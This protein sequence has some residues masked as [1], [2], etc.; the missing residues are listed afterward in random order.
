MRDEML[1]SAD[2]AD[3]LEVLLRRERA[4]TARLN[5]L[6]TAEQAKVAELAGALREIEDGLANSK[7]IDYKRDCYTALKQARQA[8]SR[9]GGAR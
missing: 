7:P 3:N 4:N 1:D 8:L 5:A 9:A 2:Y 6:L